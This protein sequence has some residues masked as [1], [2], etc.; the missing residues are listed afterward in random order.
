MRQIYPWRTGSLV[1]IVALF[2]ASPLLADTVVSLTGDQG[3][4]EDGDSSDW[5]AQSWTQAG[6]YTGV[7]IRANLERAILG[8]PFGNGFAFLYEQVGSHAV[9][10]ASDDFRFPVNPEEFTLF[11][12]LSLGPG[13]YYL[14]LYGEGWWIADL[15]PPLITSAPGVSN[16]TDTLFSTNSG[17]TFE[18]TNNGIFQEFRVTGTEVPTSATPEPVTAWIT[19]GGVLLAAIGRSITSMRSARRTNSKAVRSNPSGEKCHV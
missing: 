11:T 12:G 15:A 9:E 7:V 1:M 8:D 19:G 17:H 18:D 4:I 13:T 5:T 6:S 3:G 10:V 16:V 14:A 2:L